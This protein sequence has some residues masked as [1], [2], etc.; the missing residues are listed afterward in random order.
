MIAAAIEG[1]GVLLHGDAA[2]AAGRL[3]ID[4]RALGVDLLSLSAHKMYG[5]KGVGALYVR[6]R[7]PRVR[8]AP[9]MDG[10]KPLMQVL[11]ERRSARA[12]S[13][14]KLPPIYL[15]PAPPRK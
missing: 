4:V 7:N 5:P 15:D 6:R 13:P 8:L 11:K 3:P 14:D 9:Q 12:F 2:Q 10:G 1:R